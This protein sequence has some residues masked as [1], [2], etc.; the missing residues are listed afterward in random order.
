MQKLY[1]AEGRSLPETPWEAYPRPQLRR[2]DWLCL[3][4]TWA[5]E[6]GN[7]RTEI[8][9]PFCPESLLSGVQQ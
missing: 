5:L 4:G 9:V 6:S 7:R 8:L 2:R 1:T 3:N